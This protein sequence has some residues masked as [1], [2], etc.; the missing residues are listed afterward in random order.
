MEK[1]EALSTV[2][3]DV[4]WCS[5]WETVEWFLKKLKIGLPDDLTIPL[6]GMYPKELKTRSQILVHSCS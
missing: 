6:L 1:S 5:L 4:K 3:G 2:G